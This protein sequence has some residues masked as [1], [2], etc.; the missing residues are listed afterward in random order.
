MKLNG[1]ATLRR[2]GWLVGAAPSPGREA[3]PG[4]RA[5]AGTSVVTDEIRPSLSSSIVICCYTAKRWDQIVLAVES[6]LAQRDTASE[7][8]VVVDHNESL[9]E[10]ASQSLSSV[11][12]IANAGEQGLS[13][14]R[15]TGLMAASGDVVVFLDDDAI[16]QPQWHARLLA[17]Y[18]DD[19]VLGVGGAAVPLWEVG[20][21]RWWPAEFL[22]VVGCTFRGQPTSLS[23]VRNLMGC[24]MSVRGDVLMAVGGF[25]SGLGRTVDSPLGGEET[26]MCIRALQ[27]FPEGRFLFEPEAV[28]EHLVPAERGTWSYFFARCRAEGLSKARVARRV[29]SGAALVEETAYTWRVLPAGALRALAD[30]VRGDV[31]GFGRAIAI[32]SGLLA[33]AVGFLGARVRRPGAMPGPSTAKLG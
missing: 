16:A 21:P 20:A 25:D 1:M 22:W 24:N 14:A 5:T 15:N 18:T 28:V 31:G 27:R 26:E 12:V 3:L 32:T 2:R 6:A 8:I 4:E 19:N 23:E 33:T 11:Q 29:G 10:R 7:V 30:G 13:G 17:A 9:L